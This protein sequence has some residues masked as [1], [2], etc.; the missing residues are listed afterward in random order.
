VT[1]RRTRPGDL[2][3]NKTFHVVDITD[4]QE[5][6]PLCGRKGMSLCTCCLGIHLQL[7]S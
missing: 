5:V 7:Q 1:G 3:G 4:R 2:D 6:Y